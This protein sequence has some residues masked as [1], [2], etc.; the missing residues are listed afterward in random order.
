MV[1]IG[2]AAMKKTRPDGY[3]RYAPVQISRTLNYHRSRCTPIVRITR[4]YPKLK[5]TP[6]SLAAPCPS[7]SL[8]PYPKDQK[9]GLIFFENSKLINKSVTIPGLIKV[10]T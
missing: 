7:N 2:V 10:S 8:K 5:L 4:G 1:T 3:P 6:D 9:T